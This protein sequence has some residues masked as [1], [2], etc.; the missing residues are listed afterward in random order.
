MTALLAG[1]GLTLGYAHVDSLIV[2]DKQ[3]AVEAFTKS[4]VRITCRSPGETTAGRVKVKSPGQRNAYNAGDEQ[5]WTQ[6]TFEG[7]LHLLT[8]ENHL[9][10]L[11]ASSNQ[12]HPGPSRGHDPLL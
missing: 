9:M 10:T 6:V 2:I 1:V 5:G 4:E 11:Y 8:S 12:S 7:T 3:S